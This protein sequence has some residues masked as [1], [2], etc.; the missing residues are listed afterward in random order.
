MGDP[1][2]TRVAH[3]ASSD[4]KALDKAPQVGREA[5]RLLPVEP[6]AGT[7]VQRV[8]CPPDCVVWNWLA[9]ACPKARIS[10]RGIRGGVPRGSG[11]VTGSISAGGSD[12][13]CAN[14]CS[15]RPEPGSD[16]KSLMATLA[17][18]TQRRAAALI[19]RGPPGAEGPNRASRIR[20]VG[21]GAGSGWPRA[22]GPARR[23]GAGWTSFKAASSSR[24]SSALS[25]L[26]SLMIFCNAAVT[27]EGVKHSAC[28]RKPSLLGASLRQPVS[29]L[30]SPILGGAVWGT[31]P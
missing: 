19:G 26:T 2:L 30:P 23:F 27:L 11:A 6:V 31:P 5:L 12:A 21:I 3:A 17:S 16:T 20:R 22:N 13:K 29:W 8:S 25:A 14:N 24:R 18:T 10:Q 7:L 9:K 15:A 1:G 4:A 28:F